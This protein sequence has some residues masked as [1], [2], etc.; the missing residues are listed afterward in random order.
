[1]RSPRLSEIRDEVLEEL[2]RLKRELSGE[3]FL[4]GSYARGVHTL[5]SDIDILVVSEMF[6]GLNYPE[7]VEKVRM[8]LRED[9]G[10]DIIA[11]TPREFEEKREK[12][13]YKDLSKHWVRV[14]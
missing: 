3:V 14:D 11:L 6:E 13:F 7:R 10:F 12:A 1:M 8:K 9:L 2:R 4:F 5:E